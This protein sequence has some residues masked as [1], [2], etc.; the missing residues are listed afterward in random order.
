MQKKLLKKGIVVAIIILIIGA[1]FVQGIHNQ[2]KSIECKSLKDEWWNSKWGYRRQIVINHTFV[3]ETLENF[4]VLVHNISSDFVSH[5]Q[6]DGDDFVFTTK[7]KYKLNHEIEF[8]NESCGELISWVKLP[9]ISSTNDTVLYLYYG[10]DKCTNQQNPTEAWDPWFQAIYHM[11]DTGGGIQDSTIH[12]YDGIEH[13]TID[14]GEMGKI[15]SCVKTDEDGDFFD[16]GSELGG[17]F[18]NVTLE[19]WVKPQDKTGKTKTDF[20]I[21]GSWNGSTGYMLHGEAGGEIRLFKIFID[22]TNANAT[23]PSYDTWYHVVGTWDATTGKITLYINGIS[24]ATNVQ[25]SMTDP[26]SNT[27]ISLYTRD[28]GYDEYRWVNGHLD[29]IRISNRTRNAEWIATTY[30]NQNNP[31]T[32]ISVGPEETPTPDLFCDG[33]LS[34]KDV[35]PGSLIKGEINLSNV[36]DSYS[37]LD[38]E[39]FKWPNWSDW[40]F[41][42]S[43]GINLTPEDGETTIQV[44]VTA[45][46]NESEEFEGEIIIVNS[47]DIGDYCNIPV[48]LATPKNKAFFYSFPLFNRLSERFVYTFPLLRQLMGL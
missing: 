41:V 36:G 21:I 13:G 48:Y 34:W 35:R 8:Y 42:P 11:N 20:C 31:D 12:Q 16:L 3:E 37:S 24:Q 19:A 44:F 23:Y 46:N 4:T 28:S 32:F 47:E 10:N 27:Y 9:S 1:S 6:S 17:L 15:D 29:E 30:N 25:H 40:T 33:E 14:Y 43:Y 2:R 39:V 26:N 7:N 22:Q 38:W 45:P 5:A 18:T